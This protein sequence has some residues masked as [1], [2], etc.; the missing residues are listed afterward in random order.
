MRWQCESYGMDRWR[1]YL[2]MK[3]PAFNETSFVLYG[4][5]LCNQ[6]LFEVDICKL[7]WRNHGEFKN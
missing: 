2:I 3:L 6:M 5:L 4:H 7:F 1:Q